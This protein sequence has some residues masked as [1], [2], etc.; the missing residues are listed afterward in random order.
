MSDAKQAARDWMRG[1]SRQG[2]KPALPVLAWGL[3]GTLLA[4]LQALC[5]A[6]V[7][8]G[9]LARHPVGWPWFVG[10]AVCALARAGLGIAAE[11]AA[12]PAGATARRRLRGGIP[13]RGLAAGPALLRGGAS[14]ELASTLIDRVE[15]LDGFF[16]RWLPASMLAIAGPV[17]VLIAA[18]VDDPVAALTL[19]L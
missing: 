18:L 1:Q 7:L 11:K 19:L 17:L 3:S 9:A 8:G 6:V 15:A 2:R 4:I 5:V 12:G 13:W 14:G 10:F 16:G